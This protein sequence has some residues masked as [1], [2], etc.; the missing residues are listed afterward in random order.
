M[1]HFTKSAPIWLTGP[2]A[3]CVAAMAG[4]CVRVP[5]QPIDLPARA[6]ARTSAG[7]DLPVVQARAAAL[8]PGLARPATGIDRLTLFA[9]ILA[10]DPRVQAARAA[11]DAARR[12]AR[13]A[14]KAASPS[15]SLSTSYTND[16]SQPAPW[17]VG[18][19]ASAQL[20]FGDRR[21][22]RIRAADLG[23]VAAEYD[24]VEM[25]WAERM[26]AARGLIDVMAGEQQVALGN[27][28]I[29]LYDVQLAAMQ[30]RVN[31]GEMASLTMAPVRGARAAAA[32]ARDDAT[33]R[34]A[35]GRATI[36]GVLGVPVAALNGVPLIWPDF[37]EAPGLIAI[38]PETKRAALIGRADVLKTMTAYDQAEANLRVELAKQL[39]SI[40]VGPGFSWT[41]G[42]LTLPFAVNLQSPSFDLNRASIMAAEAHRTVAAQ[43]VESMLANAQAAI[44]SAASERSASVRA[45][46][47]LIREELP[48]TRLAADR[49]DVQVQ[50]GSLD[51]ADWA[52]AKATDAAARLAAVDALS[53]LRLA[54]LA[55]E[56]ALRQPLDGPETQI[57]VHNDPALSGEKQP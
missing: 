25:V 5:P 35:G 14:R 16:P 33:A 43:A 26:A 32:R 27:D 54:Q 9:A 19:S 44:D 47:R 42:L 17:V 18:T 34:I 40:S 37:G 22:G 46:E 23:V 12:D 52:A 55:L 13:L 20:D 56:A 57:S 51:R 29:A 8:A 3:L 39:P 30:R 4:G 49:A 10:N 53:R 38:T 41:G 11:V 2:A 31:A 1:Q 24:L 28:L 45:R 15:L 7:I 6:A 50:L 21:K 36:A 48:Q